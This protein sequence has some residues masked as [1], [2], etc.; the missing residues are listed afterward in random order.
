M[1]IPCPFVACGCQRALPNLIDIAKI[2]ALATPEDLGSFVRQIREQ[3]LRII[4]IDVVFEMCRKLGAFKW[5]RGKALLLAELFET[6]HLG[7]S[8]KA[9]RNRRIL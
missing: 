7:E 9:R 6:R 2:G 3:I 8:V 1:T 4:T 5:F